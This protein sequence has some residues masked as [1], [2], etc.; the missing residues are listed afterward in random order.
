MT[1]NPLSDHCDYAAW[2]AGGGP[3]NLSELPACTCGRCL[4]PP[5]LMAALEK[6]LAASDES[7]ADD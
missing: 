3:A 6:S 5:D 4:L 1:P 7:Q 2:R